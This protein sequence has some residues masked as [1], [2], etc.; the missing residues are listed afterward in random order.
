[1]NLPYTMDVEQ[2]AAAVAAF[3]PGGVYPYHY[4]ESDIDAFARLVAE[5]GAATEVV[6][7]D[8]YAGN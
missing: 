2:A 1:M 4:G 3:A 8:W 5:T 7:R 6:R